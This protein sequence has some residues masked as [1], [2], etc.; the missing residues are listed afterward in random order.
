[1]HV[2][3][4][5]KCLAENSKDNETMFLSFFSPLFLHCEIFRKAYIAQTAVFFK[6]KKWSVLWDLSVQCILTT[7]LSIYSNMGKSLE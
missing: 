3:K 4:A 7:L 2:L 1:M 6:R 5:S